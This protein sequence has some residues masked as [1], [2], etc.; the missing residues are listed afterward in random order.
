MG[1]SKLLKFADNDANP[2]V[3]GHSKPHYKEMKGKWHTNFFKN[4]NPLEL[5]L[6]CGYG[7]Y[8][9]GLARVYPERNFVGVDLKDA[10]IWRGA[11]FLEEENLQ[12]GGFLR[13]KIHDLLEFFDENEADA[14]WLIHPDPRPKKRDIRR[15]LTSPR[16]MEIYRKI[17]KKDGWFRLKTDSSSLF[18][19]TVEVLESG[20]FPIRDLTITRDLDNSP[21]LEEHHGIETRYE[22]RAKEND[23]Q[24]K[25]LK[26]RFA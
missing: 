12:N 13:C 14:I 20:E 23:I 21:L 9:V 3:I 22:L 25:Y 5:E 1:R 8:T 11:Q 16:F 15:R 6:A 4:Q 17:L 24:I 7:E 2:R 18:E 26:F 10:R 19:Y